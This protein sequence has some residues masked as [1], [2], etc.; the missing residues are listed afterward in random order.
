MI[1]RLIAAALCLIL[2]LSLVGCGGEPLDDA[3]DEDSVE[4]VSLDVV[5]LAFKRDYRAMNDMVPDDLKESLSADVLASAL[6]EYLD[7]KGE[8]DSI[9]STETV[10]KKTDDGVPYAVTLVNVRCASG[11]AKFTIS[12][13]TDYKLVGIYIY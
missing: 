4:S 5:D 12:L 6:D 3:F 11:T 13:D 9:K 1:K 7:D 2:A 10:G 8:F